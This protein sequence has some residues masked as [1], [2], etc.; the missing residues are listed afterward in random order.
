[1]TLSS[2]IASLIRYFF[3]NFGSTFKVFQTS[4]TAS[5]TVRVLSGSVVTLIN[6][7]DNYDYI[8]G[9]H[10]TYL[11]FLYIKYSINH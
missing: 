5:L 4:S 7:N 10:D 6:C 3:N 2:L 1:M 8:Y 11:I 9:D